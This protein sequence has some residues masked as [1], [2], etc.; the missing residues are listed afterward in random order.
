MIPSLPAQYVPVD[1]TEHPDIAGPQLALPVT[2][3]ERKPR[4]Y[5]NTEADQLE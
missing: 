3:A 4:H 5:R 1:D 2:R